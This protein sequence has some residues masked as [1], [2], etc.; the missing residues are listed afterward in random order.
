MISK[1]KKPVSILLSVI[2]VFSLFTLVPLTASA[3][4]WS[5]YVSVSGLQLGDIIG[6]DVQD[7]MGSGYTLTLEAN[8]HGERSSVKSSDTVI[9]DFRFRVANEMEPIRI[10][11]NSSRVEYYPYYQNAKAEAFIVTA[12]DHDAMTFSL[13]GYVEPDTPV[14]LNSS[15]KYRY[16][17]GTGFHTGNTPASSTYKV[18]TGNR[19]WA[20]NTWYVVTENVT[21]EKRIEITGTVNLVLCDGATLTAKQGI[22]VNVSAGALNIYAQNGGT[23][24]LYAGT[25]DGTSTTMKDR[26]QNAAI[27]GDA[28]SSNGDIKI[29]GG[30]IYAIS[31]IGA[32]GIGGGQSSAGGNVTIYGGNVTAGN[33]GGYG[34]GI[35]GGY[36]AHSGNINILGGT[37]TAF[38][39]GQN[40]DAAFGSTGTDRTVNLTIP[41]GATMVAGNNADSAVATTVDEYKANRKKYAR[42]EAGNLPDYYTVE[43]KNYDGTNLGSGTEVLKNAN[44][45]YTGEEP[46]RAEDEQNTYTFS[47]WTSSNN[48][49]YAKDATLP[50]VTGDE[51]YTATFDATPK[52]P[53]PVEV[54][55]KHSITLGGDIGV[56]FFLDKTAYD[57]LSGTK[58]VKFVLD[59]TEYT[60]TVRAYDDEKYVVTCDVVAAQMAHTITATLYVDGE[61][62]DTD[63]YSVQDYAETV[64]ANPSA[65]DSEKPE[66]LKAVAEALLHYG[67][68]AQ[69]VFA[70]SLKETPD[71]LAD[72]NMPA[73]DFSGATAENIAAAI[74]G[75]ASDLDAAAAAFDAEFYTSSLIYLSRNTLRLYFT[76]ASKTVG[77]LDGLDFSGNLSRYYYYADVADIP[78]A[79]LDNQQTFSVNGTE[80]TFSALDY[81]KAVV[82]STK[83]EP[84]QK[85]LAKALYLYNQKANAYFDAAPAPAGR[86]IVLDDVRADF[87]A[88]DGDVLTGVLGGDYQITIAADATITLKDV[89]ITC[90]SEDAEFAGITP[91]G[92]ATIILEGTNV[93]KGGFLGNYADFPGIIAP[94]GYTLTI[95]G[96]GSLTTSSGDD[97]GD[98]SGCGIG[99]GYEIDAGNI[100]I[101]G[102]NITAIGGYAA[103]GIGGGCN[104]S[105]GAITITGGTVNATGGEGGAGI[106]SGYAGSCGAISIT[107][108][109]V[110]ATGGY[111]T[112][113]IGSGYQ[114]G[115][116]NIT[117]ADT[118]TQVT[119]TKGG[120]ATNSI[121]AGNSG[122][123]GTV[124]I[125]DGANVIQ[126]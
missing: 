17:N 20:N 42:V 75:S 76:P 38:A 85:N 3:K 66:Q 69:T 111:G 11:D 73:A 88:Q 90:L 125:E 74:K 59:T 62:V 5:G 113:G 49:F 31:N 57:N 4:E 77:A 84:E 30:N 82:E 24:A 72:V 123:C 45:T 67:A 80:F 81:A 124:T 37:V 110:N 103:A 46:A 118:V 2:M 25:T 18:D 86:T 7:L 26:P 126:N 15:V 60:G 93:V 121:G 53:A 79:E 6:A 91:L 43:W 107:G 122:T 50:A 56:N 102:G 52:A 63:D 119:A 99:G 13:A 51:T 98:G 47:G 65:Y 101:K 94:E 28:Y 34:S 22:S 33:P 36:H 100:E 61:A 35:G 23:G 19:K 108:G 21:F 92:D 1:I 12:V 8:R 117:I 105:C 39:T 16:C 29:H 55:T 109:T 97:G 9:S 120:N 96:T 58:T 14:L 83:M 10:R 27:G 95:D 40:Y 71:H 44:P 48:T 114:G 115:C 64:Y 78:A 32:A 68:M 41:E 54:F 87:E 112:S 89:T 116:G 106:G 70:G 104:A